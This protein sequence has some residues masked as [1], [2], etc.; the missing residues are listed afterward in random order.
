M[1]YI[2]FNHPIARSVVPTAE[3]GGR[4]SQAV[5]DNELN[6]LFGT[7]LASAAQGGRF[8][9]DLYEDKASTIVRAELPG[10]SRDAINVEVVH[11]T[12]S[13]QAS[14]KGKP[15]EG[16]ETVTFSRLVS[17]PDEVQADKISAT[18][19]NGILTVTLPRSEEAKPRKINV[20]L[21]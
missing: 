13:I 8:P 17:I 6:W 1:R 20:T 12:L 5:I 21:N 9:I 11:G 19:E 4:L 10:V 14:R 18:Y 15:G 3:F 7:T 16:E 2:Q